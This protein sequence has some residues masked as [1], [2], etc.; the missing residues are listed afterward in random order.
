MFVFL[1]W[2]SFIAIN[3]TWENVQVITHIDGEEV[4]QFDP[5]LVSSCF[6]L[7][8]VFLCCSQ[9]FVKYG[10]ELTLPCLLHNTTFRN[11]YLFPNCHLM[12]NTFIENT[13]ILPNTTMIGCGRITCRGMCFP[14]FLFFSKLY[15][16]QWYYL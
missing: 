5:S 16:W 15:F 10:D 8:R 14:F 7:D 11:C 6:F 2:L 3:P 9:G 12:Q 4:P 1:R 13:V